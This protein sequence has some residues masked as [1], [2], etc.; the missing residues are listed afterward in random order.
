LKRKKNISQ[1]NIFPADLHL[2]L[3]ILCLKLDSFAAQAAQP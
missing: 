1:L 3:L 2:Q